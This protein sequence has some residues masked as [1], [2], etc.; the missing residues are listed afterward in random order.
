L[1]PAKHIIVRVV[2]YLTA[3]QI[4]NISIDTDAL[5][6]Y[7]D[8]GFEVHVS[9]DVDSVAELLVEGFSDNSNLTSETDDDQNSNTSIGKSTSDFTTLNP[10]STTLVQIFCL[11][12]RDLNGLFLPENLH[13]GY[14]DNA[15]RPPDSLFA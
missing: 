12:V 10:P 5:F 7:A 4:L 6:T 15:K 9:D 11:P 13:A 14:S 8:D 3:F 1:K 2:F